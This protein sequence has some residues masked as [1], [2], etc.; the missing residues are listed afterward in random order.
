[1]GDSPESIDSRPRERVLR[2][3]G[4]ANGNNLLLATQA[5]RLDWQLLPAPAPDHPI[6]NPPT[7][8]AVDQTIPLLKKALDVTLQSARQVHR[9]AFG[10]VLIQ[11]VS[12]LS[13]GM[14]RLSMYLPQL[15]LEH[16]EGQDFIYQINRRRRS[17]YAPHVRVNRL[18]KW[19]LEEY[20]SGAFQISPSQGARLETSESGFVSKLVL[21][22]NTAPD[23]TAISKDK[24]PNLFVELTAMA[25]EIAVK[26]DVP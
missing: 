18:A 20:H 15:G 19:Q 12:D 17:S 13:E 6:G 8:K 4:G 26:G 7:L 23:N 24:M 3:Q 2:E 21:D 1:M 10:V 11:Q 5:E 22:I 16:Q 9:L 14:R 25:H